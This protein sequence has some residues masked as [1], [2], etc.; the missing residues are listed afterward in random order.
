MMLL[1]CYSAVLQS[2]G[3]SYFFLLEGLALELSGKPT[4][5]LQKLTF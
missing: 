3:V 2:A 4:E 5:E 1:A